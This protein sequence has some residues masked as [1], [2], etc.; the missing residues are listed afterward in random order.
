MAN[1]AI[2]GFRWIKS[3]VSTNHEPQ[4]ERLVA[5]NNTT[6]IF[7]GDC[8]KLVSDG[9]VVVAAAGDAIYGVCTGCVRYKRSDGVIAAGNYLPATT[10]YTG[11]IA[12]TNSQASIISVTPAQ[13]QVFEADCDTAMSTINAAQDLMFNNGDFVATAGS[14]ASGRSGHVMNTASGT[15][16]GTANWRFLEVVLTPDNDVTA[17]SW[18]VRVTLNEGTEPIPGTATGT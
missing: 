16:T 17:A 2:G 15:G 8:V 14:T 7:R 12:F 4:E 3:R 18:K 11:N 6:A 1:M 5:S 9:T 13:G 10:T